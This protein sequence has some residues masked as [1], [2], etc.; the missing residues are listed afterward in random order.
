MN[1]APVDARRRGGSLGGRVRALVGEGLHALPPGDFG[2]RIDDVGISAAAADVAAHALAQLRGRQLRLRGEVGAD[3]A[4]DAGLDLVEHRDRRADLP[5]RAIAALIAVMLDEGGL[6]RMQMLRRAQPFDGGDAVAL[7]H[8]RERQAGIDP[9]P[10]DHHRAGAALAVIAALL[11]AGEMQV[12]AQRVEQR[13]PR[14]EF[15]RVALP[16]TVKDTLDMA[17]APTL[18]SCV[19]PTEAWAMATV[20]TAATAA[21]AVAA[22]NR[23]RRDISRSLGLCM[24]GP[25][26]FCSHSDQLRGHSG[27]GFLRSDGCA[28]LR[29]IST[30][31]FSSI[32]QCRRLPFALN[33]REEIVSDKVL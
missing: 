5:G 19:V 24:S 13:G 6:H 8:H 16:F 21:E 29:L 14:V 22:I 31:R 33:L 18:A 32:W 30:G 3:V 20:G 12:L 9:P 25:I 1:L 27:R 10:V 7:V 17:G 15:E 28:P 2:D 23:S 11:G 4:R 26:L